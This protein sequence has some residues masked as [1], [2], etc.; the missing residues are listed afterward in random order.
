MIPPSSQSIVNQVSLSSKRFWIY[1]Q[2][3]GGSRLTECGEGILLLVVFQRST[4]LT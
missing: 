2:K 3:S 1:T 4:A